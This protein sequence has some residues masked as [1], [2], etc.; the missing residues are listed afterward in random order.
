MRDHRVNLVRSKRSQEK[1]RRASCKRRHA[2][3]AT[4]GPGCPIVVLGDQVSFYV[5]YSIVS[6]EMT[7][8]YDYSIPLQLQ[9]LP[10]WR[11]RNRGH[12]LIAHQVGQAK[13]LGTW[14]IGK[15]SPSCFRYPRIRANRTANPSSVSHKNKK[16]KYNRLAN[17]K[18]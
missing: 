3:I 12:C 13:L 5:Q 9:L 18:L 1:V 8:C 6:L 15:S 16:L 17:T 14:G 4:R 2:R 10:E 11:E 7:V